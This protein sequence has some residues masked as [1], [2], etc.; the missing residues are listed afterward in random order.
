M[1]QRPSGPVDIL[2]GWDYFGL[3]LKRE[4]ASDSKNLSVMHGEHPKLYESTEKD[5]HVGYSVHV[6]KSHSFHATM[7]KVSYTEFMPVVPKCAYN[8]VVQ[9]GV[10]VLDR[11]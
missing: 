5:S 2:L 8:P 7:T 9:A 10:T 4:L 11:S 6:V 3:H 1:L